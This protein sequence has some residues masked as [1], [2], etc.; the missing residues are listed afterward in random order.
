MS[1]RELCS[2][3]GSVLVDVVV[4]VVVVAVVGDGG[5]EVLEFVGG[6]GIVLEQTRVVEHS[7]QR[8]GM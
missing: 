7:M 3:A 2:R 8:Y 5:A 4:L 1:S 6:D